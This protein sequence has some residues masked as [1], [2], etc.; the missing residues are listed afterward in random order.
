MSNAELKLCPNCGSKNI[1]HFTIYYCEDCW[2][3]RVN[4]QQS[5]KRSR[6]GTRVLKQKKHK[7]Y[8]VKKSKI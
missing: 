7:K 1:S 3:K 5:K 2:F 4:M 6:L 8:N